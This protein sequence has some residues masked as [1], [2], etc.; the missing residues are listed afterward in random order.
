M[1]KQ[2][3][4][5]YFIDKFNKTIV[6]VALGAF[7]LGS[8]SLYFTTNLIAQN[9]IRKKVLSEF[10][11]INSKLVKGEGTELKPITEGVLNINEMAVVY[12][13][14]K[15]IYSTPI[16][17][18]KRKLKEITLLVSKNENDQRAI[19]VKLYI[20]MRER[21][22]AYYLGFYLVA[23]PL[24]FILCAG[25]ALLAIIQI[26]RSTSRLYGIIE[27]LKDFETLGDEFNQVKRLE[28]EDEAAIISKEYNRLLKV[29]RS[30][31]DKERQFVYDAA[32][33]LRMPLVKIEGSMNLFDK[34]SFSEEGRMMEK[35]NMRS[36]LRDT[37]AL[38]DSMFDLTQEVIVVKEKL[39]GLNIQEVIMDVVESY[40]LIYEDFSFQTE[41]VECSW[42]IRKADLVKLLNLLIDNSIRYSNEAK[43]QIDIKLK[44]EKEKILLSIKDY[45]CGMTSEQQQ[46]IFEAFWRADSSRGRETGG[47]GLGLTLVKK[48]CIRYGI[49][50]AVSS[51]IGQGTTI[52]LE[53]PEAK[54]EAI[55]TKYK[56]SVIEQ[57]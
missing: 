34:P 30:Q 32:H 33:E 2:G 48:L 11:G 3:D 5:S 53:L 6:A 10:S 31:Y 7:L 52:D 49:R 8:L 18:D 29:L 20:D 27:D 24:L 22:N 47:V 57:T 50:V 15:I 35:E 43:K 21:V 9:T 42:Q 51:T 45:G 56:D 55:I 41:L 1:K 4:T 25:I 19:R 46:R 12:R 40:R 28:G 37:K 13:G 17:K 36:I 44:V 54:K 26:R 16:P 39:A 14:E 38:V 23:I